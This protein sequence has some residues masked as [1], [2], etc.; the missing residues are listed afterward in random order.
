MS[1]RDTEKAFARV[2][3]SGAVKAAIRIE[4]NS[5]KEFDEVYEV[6]CNAMGRCVGCGSSDC[7]DFDE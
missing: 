1:G 7:E 3:E 5:D 6:F 2:L 4:C